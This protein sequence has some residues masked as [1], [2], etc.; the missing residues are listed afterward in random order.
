MG[1]V[2]ASGAALGVIRTRAQLGVVQRGAVC[3]GEQ[4]RGRTWRRWRECECRNG[5]ARWWRE[6]KRAAGAERERVACAA[7]AWRAAGAERERV[8]CAASAWRAAK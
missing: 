7:S 6:A 1:G 3:D 2:E 5:G 4:A 8:A